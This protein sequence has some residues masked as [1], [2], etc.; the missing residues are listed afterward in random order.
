MTY[1]QWAQLEN[2]RG[3]EWPRVPMD[4]RGEAS[5]ASPSGEAAKVPV[6]YDCIDF[7]GGEGFSLQLRRSTVSQ[8]GAR[9]H[10]CP[11]HYGASTGS[12]AQQ[13]ILLFTKSQDILQLI[14]R[15]NTAS[16]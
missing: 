11:A 9:S 1:H 5:A 7:Q 2:S 16:L 10:W 13:F 4:P 14:S 15:K 3:Q 6:L 12:A 8:R